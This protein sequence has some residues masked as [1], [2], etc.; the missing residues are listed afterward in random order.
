MKGLWSQK[1]SVLWKSHIGFSS[2]TLHTHMVTEIKNRW[3]L[4][5]PCRS[6]T[7]E[8]AFIQWICSRAW[9]ALKGAL[10]PVEGAAQWLCTQSQWKAGYRTPGMSH[11]SYK[12]KWTWQNVSSLTLCPNVSQL[13]GEICRAINMSKSQMWE[14]LRSSVLF[15]DSNDFSRHEFLWVHLKH[16]EIRWQ[17]MA[18][19][20]WAFYSSCRRIFG[21]F[22]ADQ[23]FS[24]CHCL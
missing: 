13:P 1:T 8:V 12:E 7:A 3:A 10:L 20:I 6:R 24:C 2:S 21:C 19:L 4:P 17:V 15:A 9:C 5:S 22:Y 14:S 18:F 16:T 11:R 23:K